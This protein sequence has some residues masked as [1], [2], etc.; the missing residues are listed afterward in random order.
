MR[1]VGGEQGGEGKHQGVGGRGHRA[2]GLVVCDGDQDGDDAARERRD[3]EVRERDLGSSGLMGH[4][5]AAVDAASAAAAVLN[6]GDDA[7]SLGV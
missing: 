2:L 4:G 3:E 6:R 5:D 1:G 7:V